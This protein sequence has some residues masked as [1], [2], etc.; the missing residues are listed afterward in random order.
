MKINKDRKDYD[1]ALRGHHIEFL[2][3]S[4]LGAEAKEKIDFHGYGEKFIQNY[5]KVLK[6]ISSSNLRVKIV[7]TLDN[8]CSHCDV[9]RDRKCDNAAAVLYDKDQAQEYGL[10][11][12]KIYTS[13]QILEQ[14]NK[15]SSK[16]QQVPINF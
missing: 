3:V 10:E 5:I 16:D 4:L 12:N 8:I 14:I 11:I 1:V 13:R 2:H 6:K 15:T 9:Q 7:D